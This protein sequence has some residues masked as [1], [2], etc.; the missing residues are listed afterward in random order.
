[1]EIAKIYNFDGKAMKLQP[2][3]AQSGVYRFMDITDGETYLYSLEEIPERYCYDV[4]N[5][6]RT[7]AL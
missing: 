3:T 6:I 7:E 2:Y 1:M 4:K 5:N